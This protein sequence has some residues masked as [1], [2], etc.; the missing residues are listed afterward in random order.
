MKSYWVNGILGV[1]LVILAYLG[2]PS[3]TENIILIVSGLIIAFISFRQLVR[4]KI[5]RNIKAEELSK[6]PDGNIDA[7]TE[8]NNKI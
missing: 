3:S 6:T 2:L 8:T 5:I 7:K 1:W 4:Y